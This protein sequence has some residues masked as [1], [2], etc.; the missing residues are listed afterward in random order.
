M[1]TPSSGPK[2]K[3]LFVSP[4]P[5]WLERHGG[6][7]RMAA[8]IDLL[9]LRYD[10]AKFVIGKGFGAMGL[11]GDWMHID[12]DLNDALTNTGFHSQFTEFVKK[13]GFEVVYFNYYYFAPLARLLP[14]EI[15][16]VCDI[17]DIQHLRVQS[18]EA[19]GETAPVQA[20]RQ[21]EMN[22]LEVFDKLVS[23]NSNETRYLEDNIRTPIVT[24]PH[25]SRFRDLTF[26]TQRYPM[27]VGSKARPNL[28]GFRHLLLP[29]LLENTLPTPVLLA[30]GISMLA[31]EDTSGRVIP[32]GMFERAADI[33]PYASVSLA[34]LRFGAGLKIKVIESLVHGVP[35]AGTRCA[36]DGI[37]ELPPEVFFRFESWEEL[38]DLGDFIADARPDRVR[39]FAIEHYDPEK[40]LE[41]IEF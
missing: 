30:G 37:P 25:V 22:A 27:V 20:S 7:R 5:V 38:A 33:Y 11:P 39:E 15:T 4:E 13:Q 3:L 16:R 35:V 14:G 6:H 21:D 29:A 12:H 17:H 2:R 18:F 28:D 8:M 24:I 40:Y 19:A 1:N 41:H 23:I 36:L 26:K 31:P 9:S 34:P 32:M 10:V